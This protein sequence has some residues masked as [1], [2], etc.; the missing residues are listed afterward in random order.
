MTEITT[1]EYFGGC[2]KCGK[3]DGYVNVGR[4]HWNLCDEHKTKWPIGANLFSSW[5]EE[6]EAHWR[7]NAN[8]LEGYT[9]VEPI[10]ADPKLFEPERPK[11]RW[12]VLA[13][14]TRSGAVLVAGGARGLADEAA[15]PRARRERDR[16]ASALGFGRWRVRRAVYAGRA[17]SPRSTDRGREWTRTR[18]GSHD[19]KRAGRA[20]P[21]RAG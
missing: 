6:T 2:P 21:S 3:T 9:Q 8:L 4:N 15:V 14:R 17:A 19:A 18:A 16:H 11:C 7:R 20:L 10:S 13:A 12:Q 5:K 1:D